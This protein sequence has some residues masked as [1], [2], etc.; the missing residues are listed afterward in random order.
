MLTG[1][2][3]TKTDPRLGLTSLDEETSVD[4][5]PM[6]GD[7]PPWLAGSLMRITPAQLDHARHWFDGLAMLNTFTIAKGGVG[8]ASRFLDSQDYRHVR[9]HGETAG[10]GFA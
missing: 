3:H 1:L 7:L 2:S 10:R 5:V 8:S 9:E 6:T 4:R